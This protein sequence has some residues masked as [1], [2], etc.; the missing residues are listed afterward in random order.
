MSAFA[1]LL[2][3]LAGLAGSV[4][5]AIMG[6]L[7]QRIGSLEALAWASILSG[8]LAL[9][10]LLAARQSLGGL[11]AAARQPP[12]LWLG[13]VMGT[14]IVFTITFAGPRIGTTATIGIP[15]A[16]QLAMGA[17]I[18]RFGLFGLDRIPLDRPRAIG[19]LLLAAGAALTLRR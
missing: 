7:G 1:V 5:V 9:A 8:G 14:F 4:Q 15:I 16:G 6:R 11:A 12:W 13:A 19:I 10:V 18:D 17:V 2:A 3:L